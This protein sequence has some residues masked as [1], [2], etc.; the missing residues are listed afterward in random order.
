MSVTHWPVTTINQPRVWVITDL[1]A[2]RAEAEVLRKIQTDMEATEWQKVW[3]EAGVVY[4]QDV[5]CL[6][7]PLFSDGRKV[8]LDEGSTR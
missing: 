3:D 4:T 7:F 2:A 6:H 8:A 5:L 1:E